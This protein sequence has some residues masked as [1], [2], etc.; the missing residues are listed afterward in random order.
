MS[1][2]LIASALYKS[3]QELIGGLP[4]NALKVVIE[5]E[6]ERIPV[7]IVTQHAKE[8]KNEHTT[9]QFRLERMDNAESS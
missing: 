4:D 1:K 7:V 3:L 6:T 8:G 9:T 5:L 2:L